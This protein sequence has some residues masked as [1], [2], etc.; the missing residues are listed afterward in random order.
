MWI[1]RA[2]FPV[3]FGLRFLASEVLGGRVVGR[4]RFASLVVLI[5]P[6]LYFFDV[7]VGVM[8]VVQVLLT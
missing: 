8:I 5:P 1:S 3:M 6:L 7:R 2:A 4:V